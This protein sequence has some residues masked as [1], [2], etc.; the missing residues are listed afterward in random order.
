MPSLLVGETLCGTCKYWDHERAKTQLTNTPG[1]RISVCRWGEDLILPEWCDGLRGYRFTN[2][3][4]TTSIG[5]RAWE[6]RVG[7]PS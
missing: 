7:A 6:R 3:A 5:C 1:H 2:E 4:G